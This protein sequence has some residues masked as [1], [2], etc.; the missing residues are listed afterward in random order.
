MANR[1]PETPPR[2][3]SSSGGQ[4]MSPLS[5][6][7]SQVVQRL[8]R[9]APGPNKEKTLRISRQPILMKFVHDAVSADSNTLGQL[10]AN[11]A[12]ALERQLI[13]D[14]EYNE[15]VDKIGTLQVEMNTAYKQHALSQATSPAKNTRSQSSTTKAVLRNEKASVESDAED[16][17]SISHS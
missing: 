3:G 7:L 10:M 16:G 9:L 12:G 5:Q 2:N 11:L 17:V 4:D 8:L 1:V 15:T 6:Q 14:E 13:D